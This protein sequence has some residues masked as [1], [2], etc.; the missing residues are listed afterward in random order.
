M[1]SRL[2]QMEDSGWMDGCSLASFAHL[3]CAE[4]HKQIIK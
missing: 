1:N 3:V 2:V 4:E